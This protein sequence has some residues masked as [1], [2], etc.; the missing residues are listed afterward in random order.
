MANSAQSQPLAEIYRRLLERYGP[1]ALPTLPPWERLVGLVLG[2]SASDSKI[3][4]ALDPLRDADLLS[5]EALVELPLAE[6]VE[7]L[8]PLSAAEPKAARL[9]RV[10]RL[11][12]ESYDGSLAALIAGDRH[13][14]RER[15]RA[16]NGLGRETVD[17]ILLQVGELPQFPVN[18]STHRVMKRHAWLDF[19]TDEETLQD[20]FHAGLPPLAGEDPMPADE[21]TLYN[22][23][24]LLLDRVGREHCRK[25]P[26][27]D[28]CPLAPLLPAQGPLEPDW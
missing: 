26:R 17:A 13:A 11:V 7:L 5:P 23:L 28:D 2:F 27:C 24:Y 9:Q 21:A 15:L 18:L 4:R 1:Q 8:H 3:A 16:I 6:L 12:C 25:Q 22:E 10:M 14:L 20:Y 19:E